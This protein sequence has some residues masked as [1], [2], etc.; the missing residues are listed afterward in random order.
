MLGVTNLI[1]GPNSSEVAIHTGY[2]VAGPVGGVV[3]SVSFVLPALVLMIGLSALYF[4]AGGFTIRSD[5]FAGLQPVV[6]AAIA[7]TLWRLRTTVRGVPA[8]AV[9]AGVLALTV[10]LPS[11]EAVWLL[12]AGVAGLALWGPRSVRTPPVGAALATFRLHPLLPGIVAAGSGGLPVLAWV[13]LKT[14]LLMFGGGY[15][16]IPLLQPEV[17]A[18]G[19][20]PRASSS[21]ASPWARPPPARSPPPR[22]SSATPWPASPAR[23]WPRRPSTFPRSSG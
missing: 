20:S 17:L 6:I 7:A 5:I 23:W 21:T 15:V 1:P 3:A 16:L 2:V 11:L 8:L 4:H 10:A 18:G 9:A 22:R 19:G 12:A 14:G 13:F